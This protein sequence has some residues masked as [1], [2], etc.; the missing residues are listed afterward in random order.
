MSTDTN[1]AWVLETLKACSDEVPQARVR[2]LNG[3]NR[4]KKSARVSLP[5]SGSDIR[6][7]AELSDLAGPGDT[8]RIDLLDEGGR[9]VRGTQRALEALIPVDSLS[10][11]SGAL[12]GGLERSAPLPGSAGDQIANVQ[13]SHIPLLAVERMTRSLSEALVRLDAGMA[14]REDR[15]MS[16]V[17]SAN[18]GLKSVALGRATGDAEVWRELVEAR[19]EGAALQML[20]MDEPQQEKGLDVSQLS[21]IVSGVKSIGDLKAGARSGQLMQQIVIQLAEG[22]GIAQLKA[23]GSALSAEKKAVLAGRIIPLFQ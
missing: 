9:Y 10:Q 20:Q 1:T 6:T 14:R 15:L 7:A 18:S 12:V 4:T 19:A 5:P 21:E 17:E 22:H 2:I 16:M 23:A 13:A 11:L 8:I 3:E